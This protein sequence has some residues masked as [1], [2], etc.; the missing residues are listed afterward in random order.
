MFEITLTDRAMEQLNRISLSQEKLGRIIR[1]Y[2]VRLP[3]CFHFDKL[4]RGP[5]FEGVRSHRV[6][7]YRILYRVKN[8]E[9]IILVIG[10]AHRREV[11]D[12]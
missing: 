10:I 3:D 6:G 8:R 9:L 4:L 12:R 11:Y 2:L 1:D 7:D 5:N